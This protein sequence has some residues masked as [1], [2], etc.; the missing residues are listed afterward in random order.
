MRV[1][2]KRVGILAL[3]AAMGAISAGCTS[4]EP[5]PPGQARVVEV[6]D[7]DTL[8][9]D[10]GARTEIVRLLGVDTPET[11]HPDRPVECFGPEAS[12][13][14]AEL[15]PAGT[16]VLVER[17]VEARDR[18]DRLLAHVHRADDGTHVN[19]ALIAEGYADALIIEPNYAYAPSMRDALR[20]AR[21]AG[22]GRWTAC[23]ED[24][25]G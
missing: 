14:T 5:Y 7:G 21:A 6:V 25:A 16:E 4:T 1:R 24:G 12:G 20:E 23:P 15:L 3:V 9:L 2:V 18:F 13:R 10:F 19:L 17:D 22:Q 11:V 8:V